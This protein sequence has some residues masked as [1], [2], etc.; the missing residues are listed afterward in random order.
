[1]TRLLPLT[2]RPEPRRDP[3]GKSL[4]SGFLP[5]GTHDAS[6][7]TS[8]LSWPEALGR[9]KNCKASWPDLI[10]R[11][12]PGSLCSMWHLLPFQAAL[13]QC[14]DRFTLNLQSASGMLLSRILPSEPTFHQTCDH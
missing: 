4:H 3:A 13:R 7:S 9:R 2:A 14:M 8:H 11:H 1:M 10:Y 6:A 12:P 5:S